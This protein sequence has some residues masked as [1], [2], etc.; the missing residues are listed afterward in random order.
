MV[1]LLWILFAFAA[2]T[3]NS[4]RSDELLAT[5]TK[6]G[7]RTLAVVIL[8]QVG[9]GLWASVQLMNATD[10]VICIHFCSPNQK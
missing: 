10:L 3:T 4:E 5:W 1:L 9:L 8:L 7:L 6:N 2:F